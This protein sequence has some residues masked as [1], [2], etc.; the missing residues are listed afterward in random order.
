MRLFFH[1]VCLRESADVLRKKLYVHI[2]AMMISASPNV[3]GSIAQAIVEH[4]STL[5]SFD[6]S[7]DVRDTA[8]T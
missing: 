5:A 8:A 3:W 2:P 4:I 7:W 6:A 1:I